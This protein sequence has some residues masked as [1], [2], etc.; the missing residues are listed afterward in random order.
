[1]KIYKHKRETWSSEKCRKL[2]NTTQKD[3]MG[4]PYP[5]KGYIP[6]SGGS[7]PA[8]FGRTIYNGGCVRNGE[9]YNGEEFPMPKLA[10]G[11]KIERVPS[12]G[13]RIVETKA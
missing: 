12:W 9:W 10:K 13:L 6:G 5:F 3:G 4:T 11:F 8:R 7:L 2:A 1:M